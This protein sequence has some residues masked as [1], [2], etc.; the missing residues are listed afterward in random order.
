MIGMWRKFAEIVAVGLLTAMFASFLLQ[1]FT[2]YVINQPLGWTSEACVILY[3]WAVFWTS[4][5]LLEEREHITFSM[6]S[7]ALS[8]RP[9]WVLSLIGHA[10][11]ATAFASAL[12]AIV[13]YIAFMKIDSTPITRIRF[14]Y[15]FSIF[16]VFAVAVVIRSVL[17]LYRALRDGITATERAAENP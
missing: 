15:V 11:L 9:R 10:V 4:A 7:D 3:I 16:A 12:P 14:D 8:P 6:L 5:F 13:D 1:V 2:R 17:A